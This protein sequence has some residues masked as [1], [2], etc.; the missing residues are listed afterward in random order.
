[1]SYTYHKCRF[2]K[3]NGLGPNNALVVVHAR[4]A[5]AT[6]SAMEK[7]AEARFGSQVLYMYCS[8]TYQSFCKCT[9]L[10]SLKK[11]RY[12]TIQVSHNIADVTVLCDI[13]AR[14][15]ARHIARYPIDSVQ[16]ISSDVES[17]NCRIFMSCLYRTISRYRAISFPPW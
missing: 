1:M 17:R 2:S 5:S 11:N 16:I 4:W 3:D 8:A 7:V 15:I 10:D 14:N 9:F 6:I 12:R 13:V